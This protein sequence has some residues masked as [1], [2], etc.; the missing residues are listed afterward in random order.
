MA[1]P[2]GEHSARRLFRLVVPHGFVDDHGAHQYWRAGQVVSDA[3]ELALL[4][5]RGVLLQEE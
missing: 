5:A 2:D 1:S 4:L 3:E